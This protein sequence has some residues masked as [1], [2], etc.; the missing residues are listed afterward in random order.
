MT[1]T[2]LLDE[3]AQAVRS[4]VQL[5]QLNYVRLD[6]RKGA[7]FGSHN[8]VEPIYPGYSKQTLK[9]QNHMCKTCTYSNRKSKSLSEE[10]VAHVLMTKRVSRHVIEYWNMERKEEMIFLLF[11][12]VID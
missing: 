4:L 11:V 10:Q 8:E 6:P 12:R 9:Y 3:L 2:Q 7:N 1:G 5:Y